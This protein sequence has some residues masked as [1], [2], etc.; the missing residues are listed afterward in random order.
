MKC[1]KCNKEAYVRI[2]TNEIVCNSCNEI[3]PVG[4]SNENTVKE[5]QD[6]G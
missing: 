1:P 5:D 2:R 3:T 4:E 6:E